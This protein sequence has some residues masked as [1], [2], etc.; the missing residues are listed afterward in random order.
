MS[1]FGSMRKRR[2]FCPTCIQPHWEL[3]ALNSYHSLSACSRTWIKAWPNSVYM[4]S[5]TPTHTHTCGDTFPLPAL[6]L[7]VI[8]TVMPS[9]PLYV[10][11]YYFS[12]YVPSPL[13][14]H[15]PIVPS[16]LHLHLHNWTFDWTLL[17]SPFALAHATFEIQRV[18]SGLRCR[19]AIVDFSLRS[20]TFWCELAAGQIAQI[21]Q[22]ACFDWKCN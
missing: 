10:N 20:I 5:H 16:T 11:V 2:I 21:K 1:G 6:L 13:L 9:F 17:P 4:H 19:K 3:R 22:I 12:R 18:L 7:D 14:L 8:T 15:H